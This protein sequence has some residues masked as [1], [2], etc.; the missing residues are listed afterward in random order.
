MAPVSALAWLPG[1]S[2]AGERDPWAASLGHLA[3]KRCL[4]AFPSDD[5]WT[6][7]DFW[8]ADILAM[9]I[10]EHTSVWTDGSREDYPVG[11]FEAA[12]ADVCLPAPEEAMRGGHLG[13]C[14]GV[15]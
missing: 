1:L 6:P 7:P 5:F 15:W 9:G 4:G 12:G 11:G 2:L 14:G 8:D 13:Y 3:E 10:E